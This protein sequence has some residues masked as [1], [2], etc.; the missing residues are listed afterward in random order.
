MAKN[1]AVNQQDITVNAQNSDETTSRLTADESRDS[2]KE[3][4][5]YQFCTSARDHSSLSLPSTA[6]KNRCGHQSQ[7]SS[8]LKS[9]RPDKK[10]RD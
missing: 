3:A 9:E 2:L 1:I 6:D 10:S 8:L 5:E 7:Q 4:E